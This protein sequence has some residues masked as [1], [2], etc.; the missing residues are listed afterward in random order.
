MKPAFKTAQAWDQASLLLQP[1]M[2]RVIDN[3]RKQLE[4]SSW[5][6]E[7]E[8]IQV[9]YPGHQ[10]HLT[11]NDRSFVLDIWHLCYQVCFMDYPM[12]TDEQ[13]ETGDRDYAMDYPVDIDT[14]LLDDR[15]E[16]DW[17]QLEIKTQTLISTVF[18]RLP[19]D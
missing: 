3:L 5:Q 10:L 14:N 8:E 16:I 17:Q 4:D 7:Y 12:A 13:S 19:Q 18:N 15:G 11:R 9:P 2:I 6:G 1:I